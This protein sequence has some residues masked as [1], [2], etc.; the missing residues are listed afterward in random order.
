MILLDVVSGVCLDQVGAEFA[1]LAH[2]RAD[3]ARISV[4]HVA[5]ASLHV[6]LHDEGLDHQR[7]SVTGCLL[8]QF[9]DR[10]DAG[11]ANLGSPRKLQQVHTDGHGIKA[12]RLF[13]GIGEVVAE[14]VL[15]ERVAVD[16]GHIGTHHKCGL[17]LARDLLQ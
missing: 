6:V 16:V 17:A 4:D 7:H 9:H 12:H 5:A 1:C 8:A 15:V 10:K 14:D 2:Q 3:L 11:L 13:D